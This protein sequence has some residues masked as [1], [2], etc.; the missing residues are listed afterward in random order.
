LT[1]SGAARPRDPPTLV[2]SYGGFE[3]AEAHS[4]KAEGADPV[5]VQNGPG[6]PL[7]RE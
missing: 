4:A 5:F 1:E 2:Q 3:S 6:F 7:S